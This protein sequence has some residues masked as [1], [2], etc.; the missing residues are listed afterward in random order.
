M[1]MEEK[2]V[3]APSKGKAKGKG[4]GKKKLDEKWRLFPRILMKAITSNTFFYTRMIEM[5]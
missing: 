2:E 3:I 1:S 4:K 5:S